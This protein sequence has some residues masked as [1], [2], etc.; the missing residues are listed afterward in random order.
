MQTTI[1]FTH[2]FENNSAS[3]EILDNNRVRFNSQTRKVL[4]HMIEAKLINADAARE[5]YGIRHLARRIKDIE[6]ATNIKPSRKHN[7]SGGL[8]VYFLTPEQI[9]EMQNKE[10]E[11]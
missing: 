5:L 2:K 8:T 4:K 6:E 1:D 7:Q 9:I 10:I 3:Q 11:I